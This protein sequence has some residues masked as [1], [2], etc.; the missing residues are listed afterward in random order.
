M[1]Q[2]IYTMQ[3]WRSQ[4]KETAR[5]RQTRRRKNEQERHTGGNLAR[6]KYIGKNG[7]LDSV[8]MGEMY[9]KH[10]YCNETGILPTLLPWKAASSLLERNTAATLRQTASG[11]QGR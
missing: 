4:I 7:T 2:L 6:D 5:C 1:R 10:T 11:K 9:M 8:N 3:K